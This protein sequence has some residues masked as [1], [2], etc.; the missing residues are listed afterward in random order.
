MIK[1]KALYIKIIFK[2]IKNMLK[3]FKFLNR[4]LFYKIQKTIF[5]NYF[6]ILFSKIVMKMA[7]RYIYLFTFHYKQKKKKGFLC[8][9]ISFLWS[10]M[11][12][13]KILISNFPFV[14]NKLK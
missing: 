10:H 2:N 6:S 4:F 8:P 12:N 9:F 3:K 7:L 1:N 13:S 5:K 14:Q 11:I